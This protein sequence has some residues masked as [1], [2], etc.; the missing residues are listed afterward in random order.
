MASATLQFSK[1]RK[2]ESQLIGRVSRIVIYP[3]KGAGRIELRK[4]NITPQGIDFDREYMVVRGKSDEQSVHEF[5]TQ[6]DKKDASS[7]EPQGMSVLALIRPQLT[8]NGL[9]LTWNGNDKIE[10]AR[11]QQ[12]AELRVSIHQ[13]ITSAMDQGRMIEGWLSE[14]LKTH[15]KLVKA[16]GSFFRAADQDYYP[17]GNTLRFQDGYPVHWFMEDSVSELSGRVGK[18]MSWTRFRP[19]IVV[20]GGEAGSEHLVHAGSIGD[21]PFLDPKPCGRCPVTMVDQKTG[22][23][24]MPEPLR[25]LAKYKS[26]ISKNG[27][28]KVIFG[29]NMLPVGGGEIHLMDPVTINRLR[30]PPLVYGASV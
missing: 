24:I 19:N 14:H 25:T 7:A 12:G 2:E 4:A 15:A 1:E 13:Q 17:N 6:R 20:I 3:V 30:D 16:A 18:V 11:D 21:V 10:I 23:V 22:K 8:S 28:R 27:N 5:I 26:W 29:E 9:S